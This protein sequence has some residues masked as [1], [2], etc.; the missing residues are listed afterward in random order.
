MPF[1]VTPSPAASPLVQAGEFV[2]LR[3]DG[4]AVGDNKVAVIDIVGE[5]LTATR[6][7]GSNAHVVTIRRTTPAPTLDPQIV[8]IA[9]E[10]FVPAGGYLDFSATSVATAD[11]QFAPAQFIGG[12]GLTTVVFA[13]LLVPQSGY[14]SSSPG[15]Y[16]SPVGTPDAPLIPDSPGYPGYSENFNTVVLTDGLAPSGKAVFNFNQGTLP[17]VVWFD[18][19]VLGVGLHVGA[20]NSTGAIR[21]T[22]LDR[23]GVSLGQFTSLTSLVYEQFYLVD[24]G[25]T[26]RIAALQVECFGDD[27]AGYGVGRLSF[28]TTPAP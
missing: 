16:R 7:W 8:R 3:K 5:G 21:V 12:T 20:A 27:V 22:V 6:G 2:Q 14:A 25:S 19:D 26:P 13:P 28:T 9:A 24:E 18:D 4:V 11:P 1:G 17:Q 23:D 15:V 10:D